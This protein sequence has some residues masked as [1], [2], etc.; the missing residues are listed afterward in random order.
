[1][2]ANSQTSKEDLWRLEDEATFL[3]RS[4]E[5]ARLEFEA[6]DL[7]EK[8]YELLVNRDKERL[9]EVESALIRLR[10][11]L[12]QMS[13]DEKIKHDSEKKSPKHSRKWMVLL[14]VISLIGAL[15]I[16]LFARSSTRLPGESGSG[17]LELSTQQQITRELGQAQTL[18]SANQP[19]KALRLY[20]MVLNKD[21]KNVIALT[22]WGWL[23]WQ[24][25]KQIRNATEEAQ[26]DA[27]VSEATQ[28]DPKFALAQFYLGQIMW[29]AK[30]TSGALTHY[31]AFLND[32]PTATLLAGAGATVREAFESAGKAV[33]PGLGT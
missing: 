1:M 26:G 16:F 27:A 33:P 28:L 2:S 9:E 10:E 30:D 24:A 13:D 8:D 17:S 5:D 21:P 11:S 29:S 20:D 22:E 7:E 32:K 31:Q 23:E 3:R 25:A 19:L 14:G 12:A 4:L 15:V 6:G 18:V